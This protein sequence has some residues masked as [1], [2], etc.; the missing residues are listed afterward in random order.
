MSTLASIFIIMITK[1][2]RLLRAPGHRAFSAEN[3]KKLATKELKGR[4]PSVLERIT[5]EGIK[6]KPVYSASDLPKDYDPELHPG[7][8][9]VI[10]NRRVSLHAWSTRHN[11]YEPAMDD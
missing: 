3:W 2:Y 6:L 5:K 1:L 10:G 9:A 7:R 8:S 4:D 11:A